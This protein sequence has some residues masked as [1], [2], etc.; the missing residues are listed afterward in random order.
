MTRT[1]SDIAG[2]RAAMDGA[3]LMPGDPDYDDARRAWSATVDNRPAAIARCASTADVVAAIGY[4]RER[5]LEISVRGG[6][7]SALGLAVADAGLMIDLSGMAQV[8]V[9]PEA[10]R[11]AV[12]G[13]ARLGDVDAATAAHGLATPFGAISHTGVGGLT[14]GGGMGWLTR[15][16]G[17][18]IDNLVSAEVVTADGQVLRASAGSHPDLFWALRGG[19]GNFGV[20]TEFEFQLHELDPMIEMGFFF[21]SPEQGPAALRLVRD[22]VAT[23]PSDLNVIIGAVHAPPAPFV[24]QEYRLTPGYALVL[25]G[26]DGTPAHAEVAS[27]IRQTLPPLFDMVTPMPY[28]ALQQLMDEGNAWGFHGYVK[29][30]FVEELSDEVIEVLTEQH[31]QKN[32]PL[33]AMLLYRLDGG[34]SAVAE[35]DTA[36]GGGRSPRFSVFLIGLAPNTELFAADRTWVRETCEALRPLAIGDGSGYVND[37]IEVGDENRVRATYGTAKYERLAG[38]KAE[39]DPGN[40]FHLN[41]NIKPA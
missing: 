4:A 7:H 31:Q 10:R 23:L 25:A 19:G 36:F 17:M 33:S 5:G 41:A 32:S 15:K 26:F 38:I 27:R 21:W 1:T 39:Y 18:S 2:L 35:E 22:L 9:D 34:Y 28:V 20:V 14:L 3:V 24:P 11:A 37:L 40:L 8:T 16:F 29:A 30:T 13:G 12:G 6:A